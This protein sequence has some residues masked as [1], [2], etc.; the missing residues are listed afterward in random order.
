MMHHKT[1]AAA[2]LRRAALMSAPVNLAGVLKAQLMTMTAEGFGD[3]DIRW[4]AS[5]LAIE[6]RGP[7][8][9]V[10]RVFNCAGAC[11]TER[12]DRGGHGVERFY[13]ADGITLISEAILEVEEDR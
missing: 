2:P 4:N 9:L 12:I 6:G 10:R 3:I 11:V 8:G 5:V 7:G 13:D 1:I